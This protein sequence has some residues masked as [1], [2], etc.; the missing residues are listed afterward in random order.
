MFVFSYALFFRDALQCFAKPV[1]EDGLGLYE[2][3]KK[4]ESNMHNFYFPI[5]QVSPSLIS[6]SVWPRLLF[7]RFWLCV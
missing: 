2:H 5:W 6:E 3:H 7:H 1:H 4:S